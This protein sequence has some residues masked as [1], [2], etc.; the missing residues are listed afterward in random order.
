MSHVTFGAQYWRPGE[1]FTE[2]CDSFQV[3]F[4]TAV[5]VHVGVHRRS[6]LDFAKMATW[7]VVLCE[8]EIVEINRRRNTFH[9]TA[10]LPVLF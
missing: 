6:K 4:I 10:E 8:A 1:V 7:K 9:D 2:I 5:S 3:N